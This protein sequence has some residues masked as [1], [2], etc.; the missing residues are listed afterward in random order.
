M[1]LR[2]EYVAAMPDAA[3]IFNRLKRHWPNLVNGMGSKVIPKPV[4]SLPKGP[5]APWSW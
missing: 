3:K 1:A 4:L 2:D 5:T